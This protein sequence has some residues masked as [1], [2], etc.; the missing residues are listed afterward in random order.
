MNN[1][2]DKLL[3]AIEG[4]DGCGKETQCNLLSQRLTNLGFKNRVVSFP[5][6]TSKTGEQITSY[7]HGDFELPVGAIFPLYSLDR[8][9]SYTNDWKTNY[10]NSEIIICDRYVDSNIIYQVAQ[11]EDYSKKNMLKHSIYF[12]EYN[13]LGLP[14]PDLTYFLTVKNLDILT[15]NMKKRYLGDDSKQDIY[16]RNTKLLRRCDIVAQE[17]ED[18]VKYKN[19][20]FIN[21]QHFSRFVCSTDTEMLPIREINDRLLMRILSY[22]LDNCNLSKFSTWITEDVLIEYNRKMRSKVEGYNT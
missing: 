19:K 2:K 12:Y 13:I 16:E 4:L 22:I 18:E 20:V 6:Y 5:N 3:I 7:L 9:F 15:E 17:I 14:Q 8:Y 10:N 21:T 1:K 11:E